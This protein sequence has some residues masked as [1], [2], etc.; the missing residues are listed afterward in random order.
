MLTPDLIAFYGTDDRLLAA[1]PAFCQ[2][3]HCDPAQRLFWRD[4]MSANFAESRGPIIETD[5][6]QEW[7]TIADGRK[8]TVPYRSFEVGLHD[9]Q[10]IMATETVCPKGRTLFHGTNIA[11]LRPDSRVLRLERDAARR[12]SWTDQ[13][14]GVPN[15][16]YI[17]ERL[18]AWYDEQGIQPEFGTH[19]LAVID[20]DRFKAINDR[21]GHSV[22]DEILVAF[23][24]EV[25]DSIR[26]NDLFGRIGGEE[27]LLLM[28][29][30]S[31]GTAR[32]RLEKLL[33]KVE[34][35][36]VSPQFS[37][38]RYSFSAGLADVRVDKS[39]HHAIR[40]A[41]RLLYDAKSAGRGRV[42]CDGATPAEGFPDL[43]SSAPG[44]APR[45]P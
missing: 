24:R 27:F 32:H 38:L 17:M 19:S 31:L 13:L 26:V 34:Q 40:R 30:C 8:G 15:R 35:M 36:V 39:I 42:Q 4:I 33:R 37:E 9:G 3:Y 6:I 18:E 20:L 12:A 41:D 5:D 45:T 11:S 14:T 2:A 29:A 10:W 43:P 22:G 28:P 25:V 44:R 21:Y 16:R 7:L 23:C 1:N